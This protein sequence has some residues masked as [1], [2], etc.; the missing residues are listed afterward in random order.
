M[1]KC[2]LVADDDE[3]PNRAERCGTVNALAVDNRKEIAMAIFIV[4]TAIVLGRPATFIA[5]DLIMNR[6]SGSIASS[7]RNE[8]KQTHENADLRRSISTRTQCL[9]SST[10][11]LALRKQF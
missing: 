7:K 10:L 1:Y 9:R 5:F 6:I 11:N 2:N 4:K 3:T 8:R